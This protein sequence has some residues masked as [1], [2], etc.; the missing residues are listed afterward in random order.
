MPRR[1]IPEN[2]RWQI[3]G[4]HGAGMSCRNTGV[5]LGINRTV[6]SRLVRKHADT[7]H[8]KDRSRHG[9]PRKTTPRDNRDL[10]RLARRTPMTTAP[11]LRLHWGAG[12]RVP[13]S[14]IRRRLRTAG[15]KARRP[16]RRPFLTDRHKQVR[17]VWCGAR[18]NWNLKPWRRIH[19]SDE[20]Q[21]LLYMTD[22]RLRVWR[23]PN[24]A[25]N[26][27]MINA[28]EL[29]GGGSVMVWGC[30]SYDCKL[31]LIK[32]PMTL[33]AQRYQQEMLDA[34]VIPHFDSHPLATRPMCMNDNAR[35]SRGRAVIAHLRMNAIETLPWPARSP[36]LNPV[37]HLWDYL[38]RQVQAR[39][40]PVRNLREL[41]Q[42][43]HEE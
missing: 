31:D 28:I 17:L 25:Y 43:L 8:V 11:V 37:E 40:P 10:V 41:E 21:F 18:C 19:W 5:N 12:V 24:E 2:V 34:A 36:D 20:S 7:G 1:R 32:S 22:G 35:P 13:N 30:I 23:R 38:G 15:L 6:I 29:F 16:I 33:N 4:M 3:I 14:T 26:Q 27:Q 42:A 39:D 9:R